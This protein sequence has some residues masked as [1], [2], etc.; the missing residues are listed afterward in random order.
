MILPSITSSTGPGTGPPTAPWRPPT[1]ATGCTGGAARLELT[2][3][4]IHSA[5]A[6]HLASLAIGRYLLGPY[7]EYQILYI[8]LCKL[9]YFLYILL[10]SA[11]ILWFIISVS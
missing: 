4:L 8:K 5:L 10:C 2:A 9:M 1:L 11:S 3:S 6:I 7:N